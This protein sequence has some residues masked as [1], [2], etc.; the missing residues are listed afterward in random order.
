MVFDVVG[1]TKAQSE[2]LASPLLDQL[3][4]K[5]PL[6]HQEKA[7]YDRFKGA[8]PVASGAFRA[9]NGWQEVK[10]GQQV[11]GRYLC[12]EA[13]S[14]L[15]GKELACI[16]ELYAL[17]E[18][19]D[20]LSREPWTARFA[21]SEDVAGVNRSADK[22]FDLQESTY[23]STEKGKAYPH[24]VIID[25]GAEH[26]LTGIQYLPRMESQVPGGIKDYKIY[27]K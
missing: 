25:L 2:G 18:N 23:W 14:A 19:G 24:V 13:L 26:T 1:P 4:V 8:Q 16:A 21:D 5:K 22:I 17:D 12:V 27:V 20:R 7:A 15:D 3:Q 11:S 10:F 9:G 6:L